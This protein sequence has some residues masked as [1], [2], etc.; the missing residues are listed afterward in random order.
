MKRTLFFLSLLLCSIGIFAQDDMP[1]VWQTTL[2]HKIRFDGTGTEDRGFSYA[3]S[4]KEVTFF[5]N[6]TG[7]VVWSKKF[8]EL[9]PNLKSIDELIPFWES[10]LLFLFERKIG[11]DQIACIDMSDGKLMWTTSK[12]QDVSEYNVIY[13]PEAEGFA[14]SLKKELVFIKAKTGE[15]L[16]STAKFSGVV[17]KY[18][19]TNDNHIVAVNF[20]PSILG[21]LFS[22][23]KNQIAKIDMKN[24]DIV[25]EATYIGLAERK[26]LTKEFLFD[27]DVED[28]KVILTLN[29]IQVYD[30]STGKSLWNAAFEFAPDGV[31]R[32]PLD[33]TVW[34]VYGGIA[35][36]LRVGDDLYVLDMSN[37]RSQYVKKYDF[38]TGKLLWTSPEI[39]EAKAIPGMYVMGDKVVL[40]IG[41]VVE[42]QG[43]LRKS[44]GSRIYRIKM[45]NVRPYGVQAF[46]ANDGK[47]VWE[48]ERFR[49]GITN[50]ID[51]GKNVIVSSGKALYSLDINSGKENYEVPVSKGG[52]GEAVMILPYQDKIAVVG[53]K[54]IST[55]KMSDGDFISNGKY[56][57]SSLESEFNNIVIMKTEGA[58]IAAFDLNTCKYKQFKARKG[59]DTVMTLDG[60]FV[61]VYENKVITKVKTL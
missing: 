49:K 5:E 6:A 2:D 48:S 33:A 25:W 28:N 4:D 45:E 55:F 22:G 35:E 54:G 58:D 26:V 11:K 60:K 31:V 37:R 29:G 23:F 39:K 56:E 38:K 34:G 43:I 57:S 27:L 44:D 8:S 15:E 46:S 51:G 10:D 40:Q 12:Y 24:G 41:G 3:A 61:Y 52:V 21:A 30:Y 42:T 53:E 59:A 13:I 20:K 47:L 16:W 19:Y 50:M 14:I 9:A 18:V 36:P 17:G 7:K 1:V 32:A